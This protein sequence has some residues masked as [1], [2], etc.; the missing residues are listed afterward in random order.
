MDEDEDVVM[1]LHVAVQAE[2]ALFLLVVEE[3]GTVAEAPETEAAAV[4][5]VAA[6]TAAEEIGAD[7]AEVA[8]GVVTVEVVIGAEVAVTEVAAVADDHLRR[9][10]RRPLEWYPSPIP[11]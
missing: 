8:I 2:E 1:E 4:D 6:A 3:E 5:T 11:K 7:T 10:T 9:S